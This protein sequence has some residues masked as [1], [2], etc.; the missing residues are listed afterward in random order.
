MKDEEQAQEFA[1]VYFDDFNQDM[2]RVAGKLSPKILIVKPDNSYAV[3]KLLGEHI[4]CSIKGLVVRLYN[5][6]GEEKVRY[7]SHVIPDLIEQAVLNGKITLA[8]NGKEKRQL[9]YVEDCCIY[10]IF[11]NYDLILEVKKVLDLTSFN[12][13]SIRPIAKLISRKVKCEIELA[14]NDSNFLF[15][16]KPNKI[17]LK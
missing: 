6:Y 8:N 7:K 1:N 17:I 4:S 10:S 3:T 5:V 16:P 2:L 11:L 15:M 12:W 13:L 9:L 14:D